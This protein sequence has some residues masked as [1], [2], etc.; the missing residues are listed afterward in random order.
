MQSHVAVL[1]SRP[2]CPI[3]KPMTPDR[4]LRFRHLSIAALAVIAAAPV[5]ADEVVLTNGDRLSGTVLSKTPEGL[6]LETKYAGK[7]RIDWK[8]VETL[9]TEKPVRVQMR[10][11][12]GALETRLASSDE[13]RTVRLT[14]VPE[15]PPLK[16]ER[17][18]YLNPT[19]SQSGEGTE[20]KGRITLSGSSTQGNSD[21]THLGAEAE[22]NGVARDSRFNTRLRGEQRTENGET[23]ASNVLLSGDK[24]WFVDEKQ[25]RFIYGRSSAERD[26]FRDLASRFAAGGGYGVQLIENDDTAL[27]LK[28]GLDYVKENRFESDSQGYPALG[29][30]MRYRHWL[31]GRTAEFFHEQ[32]GYMNVDDAKDV[33]W[34]SRTGMRVPIADRLTAQVQGLYD[35]EGRPAK[36]KESGDLSLQF[37]VGYEW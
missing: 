31:S 27:S 19:P 29:W 32:D 3:S 13:Q 21:T 9:N 7:I 33:T 4:S 36:G 22:L 6:L 23:S 11:D 1:F 14:E 28:G 25:K 16:L 24:D 10:H 17:I 35:W 26:R 15:V 34:R 37:G 30:G 18:A 5:L 20:Y 8:A 2:R 12:E